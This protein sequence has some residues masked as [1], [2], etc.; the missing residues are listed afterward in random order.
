[1]KPLNKDPYRSPAIYGAGRALAAVRAK[2]RFDFLVISKEEDNI[3]SKLD[4]GESGSPITPGVYN[5]DNWELW[6]KRD[7]E[8]DKDSR[9]NL[10]HFSLGGAFSVREL[11]TDP[12]QKECYPSPEDVQSLVDVGWYKP[13]ILDLLK[14][15]RR[16]PFRNSDVIE[17]L[18]QI[19]QNDVDILK[20][21]IDTEF[22][23]ITTAAEAL[24]DHIERDDVDRKSV[25]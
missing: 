11:V 13:E 5:H 8:N 1:M 16:R 19:M 18:D 17:Q 7:D 2:W 6:D 20:D 9:E 12:P 23:A 21:F 10:I 15:I 3:I 24:R 14:E 25:V 22:Q 4:W